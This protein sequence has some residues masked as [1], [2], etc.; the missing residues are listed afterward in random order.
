ML[1][2]I[3]IPLIILFFSSAALTQTKAPFTKGSWEVSL[4]GSVGSLTSKSEYNSSYYSGESS[5]SRNYFQLAVVPGIF[6]VDGLSIEPEFNM[7]F[8]QKAKPSLSF[9][10]NLSYTFIIPEKNFAPFI[11]IGYGVSNSLQ[12]PIQNGMLAKMSD[13]FDISILNA[14]IGLKFLL[15]ENLAFRTELNYRKFSHSADDSGYG[16]SYEIKDSFTSISA[17]FGFSILL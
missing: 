3:F 14:G 12:F 1:K 8:Y 11:R 6:I 5:E 10:G 2:Y 13:K 9:L 7:F 17:L 15:T 4:S 16:Y